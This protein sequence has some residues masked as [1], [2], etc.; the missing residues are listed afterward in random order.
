M[1]TRAVA[2]MIADMERCVERVINGPPRAATADE[3]HLCQ[4]IRAWQG[5]YVGMSRR[6]T[7]CGFW[8]RRGGRLRY[9]GMLGTIGATLPGG[10]VEIRCGGTRNVAEQCAEFEREINRW[11]TDNVDPGEGGFGGVT[12]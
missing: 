6:I 8:R 5:R 2:D 4:R 9:R 10:V 3:I 7:G 11:I 1:V 12:G